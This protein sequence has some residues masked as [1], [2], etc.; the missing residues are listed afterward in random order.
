LIF[1]NDNE[2]NRKK[3]NS[4]VWK[5]WSGI[6]NQPLVST[7]PTSDAQVQ[8]SDVSVLTLKN[9]NKPNSIPQTAESL[10]IA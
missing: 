6:A 10:S 8:N 5:G 3:S 9:T 4:T 2:L 7:V 1:C